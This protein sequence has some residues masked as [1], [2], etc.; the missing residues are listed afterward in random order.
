M[1]KTLAGDHVDG[2]SVQ[3]M[4]WHKLL[5]GSDFSEHSSSNMR[6]ALKCNEKCIRATFP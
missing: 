3:Q 1:T 4:M 2:T 6:C 5:L